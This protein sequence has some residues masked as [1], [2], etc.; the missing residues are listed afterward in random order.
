MWRVTSVNCLLGSA[1]EVACGQCV[2]ASGRTKSA[3]VC[4]FQ[5]RKKNKRT[6]AVAEDVDADDLHENCHVSVVHGGRL[7]DRGRAGQGRAPRERAVP[8]D[9]H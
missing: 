7:R 5:A 2:C 9:V 1:Q 3:C 8:G 4:T 6:F